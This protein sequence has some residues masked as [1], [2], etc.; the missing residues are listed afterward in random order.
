MVYVTIRKV[1]LHPQADCWRLLRSLQVMESKA[2]L[3]FSSPETHVVQ[4]EPSKPQATN[5]AELGGEPRFYYLDFITASWVP[6]DLQLPKHAQAIGCLR[7]RSSNV[8]IN[9]SSKE[10]LFFYLVLT[11]IP[12]TVN[13]SMVRL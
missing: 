4:N 10:V 5:K 13:Y 3:R 2:S 8:C 9:L 7:G 12:W 11:L 1:A 6:P